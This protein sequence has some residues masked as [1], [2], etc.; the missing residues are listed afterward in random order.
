MGRVMTPS[1]RMET[2]DAYAW[3]K[4]LIEEEGKDVDADIL[5]GWDYHVYE[6]ERCLHCN[7]NVYDDAIYGPFDCVADRPAVAWST[8]TGDPSVFELGGDEI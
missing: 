4:R 7:V 8:S 2:R 5:Y 1:Q 6:G 3:K